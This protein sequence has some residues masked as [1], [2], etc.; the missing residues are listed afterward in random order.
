MKLNAEDWNGHK[1]VWAN[2]WAWTEKYHELTMKNGDSYDSCIHCGRKTSRKGKSLGV[3]VS[4]G[5]GAFILEADYDNYPHDGG[6]MGW[7]P[8][9]RECIKDVPSAYWVEDPQ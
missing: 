6:G 9:G 5:G 3:L 1:V 2:G 8:V 7:F 4:E